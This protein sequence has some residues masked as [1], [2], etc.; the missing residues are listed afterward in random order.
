V[1]NGAPFT[2]G[3]DTAL[4]ADFQKKV[5]DLKLPPAREQALIAEG[6]AALTGP[7]RRGYDRVLAALQQTAPKATSNDGVWRLPNGAAY[8]ENQLRFWTTTDMTAD[9][10]HTVGVAEVGAHS[11]GD[12][13]DQGEGGLTGSLQAFFETSRPAASS[14]TPST[15]RGKAAYLADAKTFIAGAMGQ[16]APV[17]SRAAQGPLDVRAVRAWREASASVAFY[18]GPHAGRLAARHLLRNL[19]DMTQVLKP[20]WRASPITRARPGI[21]SRSRSR[22]RR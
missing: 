10:I 4:W 21:T 3:A 17:L 20:R 22:R 8:Y 12:G 16:G 11:A 5:R 14:T 6:R 15:P 2:A 1:L 9:Q 19:A 13:G 7:F 18:N